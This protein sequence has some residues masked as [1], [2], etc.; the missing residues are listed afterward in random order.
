MG[1]FVDQLYRALPA[2]ACAL[3]VHALNPFGF[4]WLRRVNEDGVDLN[5]NFV[6]FSSALPSSTAYESLHDYLVP[7]DW[8]GDG[9]RA[10]DIGLNAYIKQHGPRAFQSAI[11]GG[12]YKSNW[13]LSAERAISVVQYLIGRGVSPQRLLAAGFGEFQPID[14]AKTDDAYKRNRRI[15]LK[16][17]ER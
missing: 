2:S 15:E 8:K 1:F 13:Q 14:P 4:A 6:D 5:R 7:A 11:T 17:T 10:A 3:L 9:R 12:Q 16:L